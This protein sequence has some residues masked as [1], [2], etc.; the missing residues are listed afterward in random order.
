MSRGGERDRCTTILGEQMTGDGDGRPKGGESTGREKKNDGIPGGHPKK[1][2]GTTAVDKTPEPVLAKGVKPISITQLSHH[3]ICLPL[4]LPPPCPQLLWPSS[5]LRRL[6][7]IGTSSLRVAA[8]ARE[9][10]VPEGTKG[11]CNGVQLLQPALRSHR[12]CS[13]L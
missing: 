4:P 11:A 9:R 2:Q 13:K 3:R 1:P 10:H 5:S 7:G 8:R 12:H 6:E